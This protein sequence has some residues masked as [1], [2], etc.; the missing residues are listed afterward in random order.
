MSESKNIDLELNE[1]FHGIFDSLPDKQKEKAKQCKT[2]DELIKFA[3]KEGI[4]I[5]DGVLDK[6]SGGY[7]F[8]RDLDKKTPER[9]P[10]SEKKSDVLPIK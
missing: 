10:L 5:P 2:V 6:V 9:G 8:F 3:D 7:P 4:E 1:T